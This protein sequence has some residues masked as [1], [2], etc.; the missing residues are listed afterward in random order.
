MPRHWTINGRFL[1]QPLTGVQRYA[2]EIVRQLDALLVEQP[3]LTYDLDIEL[4]VPQDASEAMPL[5]AIRSRTIGG[6]G[7]H[8]WEQTSLPAHVKGG[9]VSLC[10][11]GPLAIRKQIVCMHDANTRVF[12]QSYSLAFRALYRV[13]LPALGRSAHAVSTVSHHSAGEL[14]RFGISPREKVFVAPNG[15]E[16]A[17]RWAARH[18]EATRNAASQRTVVILGSN[19]P[20]KNSDLI[21]SMAGRL[22]RAGLR[23]AVVGKSDQRVF[24]AA[25][26]TEQSGNVVWLGRLCDAELAALLQDSLCLAF[27]SFVEGFGLPPLEAMAIGCPVVVSDRASLPEICG[28]AALYASPDSADAWFVQFMRLVETPALRR[29]MTARGRARAVQYSWRASAE[30]YLCA[31]ANADGV[32]HSTTPPPTIRQLAATST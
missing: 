32:P 29:E 15:H 3:Q 4:A 7:G 13:L 25:A 22:A 9:L 27:P 26:Q 10:N 16:H 11:T 2:Y 19:A 21:I 20:H 30:R 18:S 1:A 28:D 14:A 23:V 31:M 8:K 5:A 17:A 6:M 12:P 24:K